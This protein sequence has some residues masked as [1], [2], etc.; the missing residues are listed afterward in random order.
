[1]PGVGYVS[2]GGEQEPAIRIQFNPAQLAANGLD[3]ETV[4]TALTNVSVDQP[5]GDLYGKSQA[6]A[7]QT[8][9]QLL[10]P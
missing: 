3:L 8:N 10:T 5:K 4:R 1:M 2:I 7:L 6:Y 9:D